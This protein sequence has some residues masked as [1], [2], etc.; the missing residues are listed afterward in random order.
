MAFTKRFSTINR[1]GIRFIGNTLGLSKASNSLSA[2]TLGSIGA[3]ITLNNTQVSNFPV[4]TTSS[5]LQNG[6]TATLNLPIGSSILYAELVWGGLFKSQTQDIS[7]LLNNSVTLNVSN[8]DYTISPN[9][10]TAQTFLIPNNTYQLG[11]YVR[12]ADVT[13]I[14][15]QYLNANYTTKGVPA[16]IIANESQTSDTNHAGWT[17]CVVY[18]NDNEILRNLT[19]WVGGAVVGP[20]TPVSDTTLTG[21]LTPSTL[22]ISGKVFISAQEG[23]AVISGDQF[24]FGKNTSSLSIISGPNNPA[25]N[26]F[27]SQINNENGLIDTSG[28]FGT[29]NANATSGTNISA[30]RQGWDITAV[31]VSSHL[32]VSQ[33]SAVFR[34]TSSGDLYV[35]NA[36]AT[37]IDS[38]GAFLEVNKSVDNT[39]KFV[40]ENINY[41][42]TIKNTGQI[43]ASNLQISDLL[44]Q[45]LTLVPNSI[46]VD[47][48]QQPDT[49]PVTI[50][51]ISSGQTITVTYSLI[52]NNL[53][54]INPAINVASVDFTFTPFENYP[55]SSNQKSNPVTVAIIQENVNILKTVDKGIAIKGDT[56][57]YTSYIFNSGNLNAINLVFKDDIPTGTNFVENS[58]YLDGTNLPG[59]NPANGISLGT[60]NV[61]EVK[62]IEFKVL[63]L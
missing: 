5:Y 46:S 51:S 56:L 60:I 7:N 55:V 62:K 59:E 39:V 47:G 21:F 63:V 11:F 43:S 1:G 54:M 58:L 40:G 38:L 41:T 57:T 24:L 35:P 25:N 28:T 12:S 10:T 18:K 22:P 14:V 42:L 33:S 52:A 16:L 20:N 29:R 31:D 32:E 30:G 48:I 6:S 49:F 50:S 53:P 15:S 23:D 13:N 17:L 26:F 61:G 19:L 37:T 36:L 3:F 9:S 44:P 27:A 8:N 34:F 2:G 45:G 4:G